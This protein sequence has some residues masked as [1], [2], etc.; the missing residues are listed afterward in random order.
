MMIGVRLT[1]HHES[2]AVEEVR[3]HAVLA[4]EAKSAAAETLSRQVPSIV[5]I[6]GSDP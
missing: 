4:K 6:F 5:S 1:P 2:S 3:G